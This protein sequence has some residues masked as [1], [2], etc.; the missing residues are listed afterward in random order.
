MRQRASTPACRVTESRAEPYDALPRFRDPSIRRRRMP[1]WSDAHVGNKPFGVL[2]AIIAYGETSCHRVGIMNGLRRDVSG[3]LFVCPDCVSCWCIKQASLPRNLSWVRSSPTFSGTRNMQDKLGDTPGATPLITVAMPAFN[4]AVYISQAIDSVLA[5]TWTDFELLLIDDGSGDQTLSI[6]RQYETDARVRVVALPS[7]RGRPNA[8]GQCLERAR[9]QYIAMLDADDWCAPDRLER[10]LAYLA[11]HPEIAAVGT[12]F[13]RVDADG[14]SLSDAIR[15]DPI[16]PEA[17]RCEMLFRC[18]LHNPTVLARTAI[19]REYGYDEH[20]HNAED[21]DLWARMSATCRMANLALKLTSYRRHAAQATTADD[22]PVEQDWQAIHARLLSALGMTFNQQDLQ[23]HALLY[24]GRRHFRERI[25]RDM[26]RAYIRWAR[27]WLEALVQANAEHRIYPEP[28][29]SATAGRLWW[30]LCRKAAR[31]AGM[32]VWYEFAR[33]SLR[34]AALRAVVVH[35][36][37]WWSRQND[38]R[39]RNS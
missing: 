16:T 36:T 8:R 14:R 27:R 4:S 11:A 3:F 13:W 29:F 10:Q 30:T 28:A 19:L 32:P 35:V 21:Y 33:S 5:Q 24:R 38:K 6:M 15:R 12:W 26:D 2:I 18:P 20:F 39:E 1:V 22:L 9:G 25:G 7:N 34:Q 31:E 37:V 23:Y 17:V